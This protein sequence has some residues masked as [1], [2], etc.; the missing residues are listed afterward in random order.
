MAQTKKKRRSKHRG[1]AAGA[2]EARGRTGRPPSAEEKKRAKRDQARA[3]R[4]NAPPTWSGSF[5]RALLPAGA[6]FVF[7]LIIA[8][9]KHG[10]A[11]ASALVFAVLAIALYVPAGYALELFLY[12]RRMAKQKR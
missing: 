12:R 10:S 8:H 3:S 7:L 4:L 5:K 11:F 2:I 6:M 9:P 1:N